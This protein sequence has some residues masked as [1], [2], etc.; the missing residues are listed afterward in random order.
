MLLRGLTFDLFIFDPF[1]KCSRN[2]VLHFY[3]VE[4]VMII[5]HRLKVVKR[6]RYPDLLSLVWDK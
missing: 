5:T 1:F 4:V 2:V 3:H 6:Q